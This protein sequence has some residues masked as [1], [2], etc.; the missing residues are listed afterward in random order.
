[1]EYRPATAEL[2]LLDELLEFSPV[3]VQSRQMLPAI[4][5]HRA[6]TDQ[7]EKLV[8]RLEAAGMIV[9]R[10]LA[11]DLLGAGH[12][13][14]PRLLPENASVLLNLSALNSSA[15]THE[16]AARL[17]RDLEHAICGETL[18]TDVLQRIIA[19]LIDLNQPEAAIKLAL[20]GYVGAPEG[21]RTVRR[22]L[23]GHIAGLPPIGLR[24]AGTSSTQS[25]VAALKY[26][27]AAHG[28]C[29]D[30]TD[31]GYASVMRELTL[32]E[33][34][35]EPL[36]VLLDQNYFTPQDW[37][38]EPQQLR[39]DLDER[40][41]SLIDALKSYCA[42]SDQCVLVTTLPPVSMPSAGFADLT[43]DLGAGYICSRVNQALGEAAESNAL[44]CLVDTAQALAA[45]PAHARH[46]AKLWFYGRFAYSD[47]ATRHIASAV[48]RLWH[49]RS[50]GPAKILAL[51]FDNTL[52]GGVFGD[53]GL[54][55]LHCGDDFPGSAYKALQNECLRLKS[56][57]MILVGLSKNNPDALEVFDKHPGMLLKQDDFVA[58]AVDW[59]AKP[60]NI[61]RIA[62]DL[63]LGLDT[64]LFIDDSPHER[65][66]MRRLCPEVQCPEMPSDPAMR[67]E[68]IRALPVTWP[69]RIT[70]EDTQRSK[71][72]AAE[73]KSRELRKGSESY[74]A[75]LSSLEQ[76]LS[77]SLMSP[78]TMPRIVQLHQRTNQ[79]NLTNAR[80]AESDLC[81]SPDDERTRLVYSGHVRDRFGDHG[82]VVAAVVD[83]DGD[84]A[85]IRSFVMSCRVIGRKIEGA[86]LAAVA[87]QLQA[88]RIRSV[89][90]AYTPT[91]KNAVSAKLYPDFGFAPCGTCNGVET[92]LLNLETW[93]AEPSAAVTTTWS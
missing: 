11:V 43:F 31:C 37:R 17:A 26:T 36:I 41:S 38:R 47:A 93:I 49:L 48:A 19:R 9:P 15:V 91:Q 78:A 82:L 57:G 34:P 92:W 4:N 10:W 77:V 73:F 76:H 18:Q 32:G 63:G 7:I 69:S 29:A 80:F 14:P 25:L 79:F 46:E 84:A 59:N 8:A 28:T 33:N 39:A 52:W 87:E 86:F 54:E 75:Y 88:M 44:I 40:V 61:R 74:S 21:L 68:W 67:P 22:V 1:M 64:V 60:E 35:A 24:V 89:T 45:L 50:K 27:F 42:R 72:Y 30:V 20:H 83:I 66:A 55:R 3:L 2:P 70:D 53:D 62:A 5:W 56:Q 81:Q 58:A 13:L 16:E 51:D 65:E 71:Y 12:S 6:R 90:G 23:D 85:V